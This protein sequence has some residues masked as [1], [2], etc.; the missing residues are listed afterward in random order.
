MYKGDTLKDENPSTLLSL[1]FERLPFLTNRLK[2]RE[3]DYG[4]CIHP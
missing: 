2:S 4:T 3:C 1:V